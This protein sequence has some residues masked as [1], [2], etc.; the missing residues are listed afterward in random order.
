MKNIL[1]I[2]KNDFKRINS[3][4]VG[5]VIILGLCVVP[6]LYAWFNIFSNWDPCDN[7]HTE[8]P[9]QEETYP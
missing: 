3:S 5:L 2:I 7:E 9:D 6:C 4:V 8:Y 1:T